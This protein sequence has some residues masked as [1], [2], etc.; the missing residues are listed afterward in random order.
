ME[1]VID[2]ERERS[3]KQAEEE[4]VS[5]ESVFFKKGNIPSLSLEPLKN[6]NLVVRG[7]Y[8]NTGNSGSAVIQSNC[9]LG[10]ANTDLIR[11]GKCFNYRNSVLYAIKNNKYYPPKA[12]DACEA[13]IK[14]QQLQ[15]RKPN[16]IKN[17][18]EKFLEI[19]NKVFN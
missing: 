8:R 16:N 5:K 7:D 13:G 6:G 1:N 14:I 19:R 4:V 10:L 17:C 18:F 11:F 3:S 12:K 2:L 9:Q 15:L